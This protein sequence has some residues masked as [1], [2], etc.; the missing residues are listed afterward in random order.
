[1]LAAMIV[2]FLLLAFGILYLRPD[3]AG[4]LFA[5][6]I[7]P[8]MSPFLHWSRFTTGSIALVTYITLYATTPLLVLGVWLR[9][10]RLAM[11]AL[12]A[13]DTEIPGVVRTLIMTTGCLVLI[14]GVVLFAVPSALIAV[15]PWTLTPLT[16][17]VT[18]A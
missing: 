4:K 7:A 16:A 14:A 5:W 11:P 6:P 8:H 3:D 10:R 1:M 2:P 17:R 18:G 13:D 15:W 9:N 12:D